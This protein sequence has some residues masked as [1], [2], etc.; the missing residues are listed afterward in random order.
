[1]STL[2]KP[3]GCRHGMNRNKDERLRACA[4]GKMRNCQNGTP[5]EI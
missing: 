4:R 2:D 3:A 1:M 5:D